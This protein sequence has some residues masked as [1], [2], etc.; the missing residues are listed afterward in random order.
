VKYA[1]EIPGLTARADVEGSTP[2]S[3]EYDLV[4]NIT[5]SSTA[6]TARENTE[7]KVHVHTQPHEGQQDE[8]WFQMQDLIVE[9]V[10]KEMVPLGEAYIQ[11]RLC[12]ES[13]SKVTQRT[14]LGEASRTRSIAQA[15]H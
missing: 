12:L 6:G 10:A 3:T 9:S 14:G 11:V 7:W 15:R 8:R 2:L 4:A 5:H 13:T 1:A